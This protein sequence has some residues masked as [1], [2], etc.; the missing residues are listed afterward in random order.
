MLAIGVLLDIPF[1]LMLGV[2]RSLALHDLAHLA[3]CFLLLANFVFEYLQ[4]RHHA[5]CHV[6]TGPR[7]FQPHGA[8]LALLE[9]LRDPASPHRFQK[10]GVS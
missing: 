10:M 2:M 3:G 9:S 1:E 4:R 6:D 8:Y 5:R 7:W